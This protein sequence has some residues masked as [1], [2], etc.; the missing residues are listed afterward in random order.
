MN[1]RNRIR[2]RIQGQS[3]E[4]FESLQSVS[5]DLVDAASDSMILEESAANMDALQAIERGLTAT[6]DHLC[7]NIKGECAQC[8][9][10][11]NL[12][13]LGSGCGDK[14]ISCERKSEAKDRPSDSSGESWGGVNSG[15]NDDIVVNEPFPTD[16][17]PKNE[18]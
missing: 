12:E 15:I 16:E 10:L 3:D 17:N 9:G 14:C 1:K 5:D 6:I 18:D 13:R 8:L 2:R 7:R 4:S 11:I